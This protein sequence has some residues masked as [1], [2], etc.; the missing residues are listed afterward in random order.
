MSKRRE[1]TNP[2]LL[3]KADGQGRAAACRG[4]AYSENPYG[5]HQPDL[6]LAWSQGHN[7]Q[8]AGLLQD[9]YG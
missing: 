2:D 9:K 4:E 8:R 7:G 3:M 1:R 5:Q 6:R